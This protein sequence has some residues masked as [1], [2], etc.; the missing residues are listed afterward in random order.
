MPHVD[1]V[2]AAQR[3]KAIAGETLVPVIFLTSLYDASALARCLEAGG[4]DFLP[5]PY[6]RII[7]EAKIQAFNRMREMHLTLSLQRDHIRERNQQLLDEQTVARRVF[8]NIAHTGCLDA[9]NI[10]FHAS[11]LS[12]F[13][14]DVLFACPQ[15][16]GGMNVLIGDFTGHGLPAAIG[17]MPLAEIFY[18]MTSKGFRAEDILCEINQKLTRILPTDM[19]CCAALIE[20]EFHRGTLTVWNGGLPDGYL[21]RR[22]GQREIL[23]SHHLPLGILRP[24]RFS[25]RSQILSAEAGD[26]LFFATDGVLEASNFDGEMFGQERLIQA[27]TESDSTAAVTTMLDQ[28]RTFTGTHS[29]DD[30]LTLLSLEMVP[31]AQIESLGIKVDPSQSAL[32]GP[33]QW[34]CHYEIKGDTLA[35]FNPLPLMLHICMQVPG[36]QRHSGEVYTLLSE[37]YTN[38]LEHGILQLSS[39]WKDSAEGF[40]RYYAERERR[41]RMA[42]DHAIRFILEH[43]TDIDGGNLRVTCEDTGPG[44]DHTETVTTS[45]GESGYAGRGL[46]LVHQLCHAVRHHGCGNRVEAVYR[47]TLQMSKDPC[48][49]S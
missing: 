3:I 4:D 9:P 43:E 5:K 42:S 44:F 36:L 49:T 41:L 45:V 24:E 18:G 10:R 20:A 14:G 19:F 6:N 23:A 35:H 2:E 38:A 25:A 31:E 22:N 26:T 48:D 11:P 1:G 7:I 12:V 33:S 13:N 46:A 32:S 17:A 40:G 8:D 27:L 30:D 21:L 47:W 29:V 37:L 16:L 39:A 15:P 34:T 28:V